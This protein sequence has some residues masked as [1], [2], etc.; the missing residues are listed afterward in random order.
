MKVRAWTTTEK[1]VE[2]DPIE[3]VEKLFERWKVGC[4]HLTGGYMRDG[5]WYTSD[6]E[7]LRE[8]TPTEM[9]GY[10]AFTKV[11]SIISC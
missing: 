5:R 6:E 3:V 7:I 1:W 9:V 8:A 10:N 4:L 11:L 2:I